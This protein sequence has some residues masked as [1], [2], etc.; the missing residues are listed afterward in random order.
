MNCL[1]FVI[2]LQRTEE[3]FSAC[4]FFDKAGELLNKAHTL[5]LKVILEV[6]LGEAKGDISTSEYELQETTDKL[7]EVLSKINKI[8]QNS[9]VKETIES[10]FLELSNKSEDIFC[11]ICEIE[12]KSFQLLKSVGKSEEYQ[13]TII[14]LLEHWRQFLEVLEEEAHIAI[15]YRLLHIGES[16]AIIK[17][18]LMLAIATATMSVMLTTMIG[19][20]VARSITVA[21]EKLQAAPNDKKEDETNP[22][23]R[24]EALEKTRTGYRRTHAKTRRTL[25]AG[26]G[27]G[28]WLRLLT[29]TLNAPCASNNPWLNERLLSRYYHPILRRLLRSLHSLGRMELMNSMNGCY[30][31]KHRDELSQT[32]T[33]ILAVG[34]ADFLF[35]ITVFHR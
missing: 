12:A 32:F 22:D 24:F 10:K 26:S 2:S 3:V 35:L 8:R 15:T 17:N 23:S 19:F 9:H 29:P 7:K 33:A 11:N 14:V 28:P 31:D 13:E 16:R 25:L 18:A 21:F 30:A 34:P 6:R 1:F 5:S 4:E 27:Q 20:L